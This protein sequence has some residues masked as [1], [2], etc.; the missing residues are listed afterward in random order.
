M[1]TPRQTT[2]ALRQPEGDEVHFES[3]ADAVTAGRRVDPS[4][5]A[6]WYVV[7]RQAPARPRDAGRLVNRREYPAA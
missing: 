4:D 2:Y 6:D 3:L 5:R 1:G 7:E